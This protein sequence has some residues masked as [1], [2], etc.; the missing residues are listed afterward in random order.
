MKQIFVVLV[1]LIA[2]QLLLAQNPYIQHY[3]TNDGLPSN[4]VYAMI[5]DSK[6]FIWFTSD[7]GVA[8]YDGKD[9]T[10]FSK[11]DGLNSNEIAMIKEDSQGR[12]WFFNLGGSMN[13]FYQNKI[14]NAQNAPFLDSLQNRKFFRDFIEDSD[15]N[16]CFYT[17]GSAEIAA[18]NSQNQVRKYTLRAQTYSFQGVDHNE[19]SIRG[20]IKSENNGFLLWTTSGIY[21]LM[22]FSEDPRQICDSL[23]FASSYQLSET[24]YLLQGRIAQSPIM[25]IFNYSK[26]ILSDPIALP[27][28]YE[29][30]FDD[31]IETQDGVLWIATI[32]KGVFCLQNN[33]LI[34]HINIAEAQGLMQDH[35]GNAWISSMSEGVYK[36][37]PYFNS[38][39][40]YGIEFFD[41]AGISAMYPYPDTG[42]W[43]TNGDRMYL[44]KDQKFCTLDFSLNQRKLNQIY[45]LRNNSLVVGTK[46]WDF[47]PLIDIKSIKS[48]GKIDYSF[49][50]KMKPYIGL[51]GIAISPTTDKIFAY[52]Q[53]YLFSINRE[54]LLQEELIADFSERIH[55]CFF[56]L[57]DELVVNAK[58]NYLYRDGALIPYPQLSRFDGKIITG[59]LRIN[60]SIEVIN[61]E[62]DSIYLMCNKRI[63]NL[64]Q[65]MDKPTAMM[66]RKMAYHAPT[67]YLATTQNIFVIE[68][69]EHIASKQ[70]VD[71][72]F[73]DINFS[74]I[75]EI[76][77]FND[78]LYVA[79]DYGLTII[80]EARIGEMTSQ[81]PIPYLQSV[82][83]NGTDVDLAKRELRISGKNQIKCA[84]SCINYSAAPI[85]Y[86][87]QLAG[88]DTSWNMGTARE[89]VYQNLGVGKY[90]FR[91]RAQKPGTEFSQPVEFKI[92]V[93]ATLWQ[94]P[95]FYIALFILVSG[96]I[97]WSV[98]RR[99][100]RLRR[101]LEMDNQL[102]LLEQKALLTMM[103]PHFIFN[104]L[105]SVQNHLL[106]NQPND[107][108]QY[109]SQ[110]ARLI[111]QNLNAIKTGF[112]SVEEE[113]DRLKNYLELEKLRM[114]DTFDYSIKLE[115]DFDE[116]EAMIPSMIIQPFVENAVW[117][118]ISQLRNQTGRIAIAFSLETDDT[119]KITVEDNGVGK[120]QTISVSTNSQQHLNLSTEVTRRRLELLGKKN[121]VNTSVTYHEALPGQI[122]PGTKVVIIAPVSYSKVPL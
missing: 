25:S 18:L 40:H 84:F 66:V 89:V 16:L 4:T 17:L 21:S 1:L 83:V 47:Y 117:H 69:P 20:I 10:C 79:S 2:S 11:K 54:S 81:V 57:D 61:V 36:I 100:L 41:N 26:G 121:K 99:S 94:H 114:D 39:K 65:A 52:S 98:H 14:F 104:A 74:K 62:G 76:L 87:Y 80:P 31:A 58:K 38:H 24:N 46:S 101:A 5:R 12:I 107:A 92:I 45:W 77:V 88:L 34:N 106:H 70:S 53:S 93:S 71:L 55:K 67:L 109:L 63:C 33:V 13:Y 42:V 27:F 73:I 37:S 97:L 96:W 60:D 102:V 91:V 72:R 35:E 30:H 75:N 118:G 105:G 48:T 112:I 115:D 108:A 78:S 7:A 113:I 44:L 68:H 51:K 116:E 110:F 23:Y 15:H 3:N 6:N 59:H 82:Q 8:R 32:D 28:H 64:T 120:S 85:I 19:M 29:T 103:N 119:I 122:N 90:T 43:M 111:R 22:D 9:F 56:N 50:P 95:L 86:S 49:P